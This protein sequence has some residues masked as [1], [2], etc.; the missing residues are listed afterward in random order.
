MSASGFVRRALLLLLVARLAVV[1]PT[2][3]A[4]RSNDV[5]TGRVLLR[6]CACA[7]PFRWPRS[8]VPAG[9]DDPGGA[10]ARS[11]AERGRRPARMASAAWPPFAPSTVSFLI[12]PP[13]RLL[14]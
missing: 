9:G 13:S 2:R 8:A 4:G 7:S 6:Y 10:V 1:P 5:A 12:R 14:C 11:S 3:Q